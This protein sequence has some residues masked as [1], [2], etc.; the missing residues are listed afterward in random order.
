M[1][2]PARKILTMMTATLA[3]S[4]MGAVASPSPTKPALPTRWA[5]VTNMTVVKLDEVPY[6]VT[7]GAEPVRISYAE[8]GRFLGETQPLVGPDGRP[9]CGNLYGKGQS[10]SSDC[11]AARREA[12]GTRVR[13]LR[14]DAQAAGRET[15]RSDAAHRDVEKAERALAAA[16]TK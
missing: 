14:T 7:P 6:L 4:T 5:E 3:A 8:L 1:K 10:P 15:S 11:E 12:L 16:L 9:G 2:K 13:A